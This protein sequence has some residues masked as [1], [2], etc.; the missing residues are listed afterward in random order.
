MH[1]LSSIPVDV[2][3]HRR[4]PLK[5]FSSVTEFDCATSKEATVAKDGT[6]CGV[7]WLAFPRLIETYTQAFAHYIQCEEAI[8]KFGLMI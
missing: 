3:C 6:N 1:S 7:T 5:N 8:S 4:P 2:V